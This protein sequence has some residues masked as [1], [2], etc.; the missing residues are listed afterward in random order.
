[1][2]TKPNPNFG[3]LIF[4]G[5]LVLILLALPSNIQISVGG[6]TAQETPAGDDTAIVA[7]AEANV[8]EFTLRTQLGGDPAMAFLGVGGDIDDLTNPTLDVNAGDTVRLTVING[9]PMLHDLRI[10]EF[11]VHTGEMVEDEQT[12]TVEFVANQAGE[13]NYYCS[14]PGHRDVGMQG[15]IKVTGTVTVSNE[16]AQV[17]TGNNDEIVT[18]APAM[19]DAVSIVRNPADVPEPIGDR[20]ATTLRVDMNTVEVNGILA[21]GTT[22]RYMTFDGQVPGPMLRMRVGDTMEVHLHNEIESLLSHSIDL[23]AVTGPGGGAVFTQTVAGEETVFTFQ[24]L[25]A[26]LYVYHCATASIGHHISSGM[27]GLILVEPV[28]G[29]PAVD[30]EFYVMQGEIY[31]A[32]PFGTKGHLDF[33]HEKM[34]DEDAEYFVFN[35]SAGALTLDENAMYANVGDTVRIYFGVGGPNATSSVHVIGEIF[36]RVYDQASLTAPPLTD[37]QTTVVPPG[38]ATVVEFTLDVPGRYILVDHALSRLERGLVGFL[39]AEGDD[40]PAVFSGENVSED[41]GH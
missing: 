41:S 35:G 9:D 24:A 5:L 7:Q 25:Q 28:G 20:A 8:V 27:Y 34:L 37:V 1:M 36:D 2:N 38:G 13:F 31:T 4:V 19:E 17:D 16:A 12:V 30:H 32:Q 33:S 11:G 40:N 21:D 26:G 6:V 22:Y 29:L 18:T 3:A 14:V 23:H 15:L 10:D 39:Y